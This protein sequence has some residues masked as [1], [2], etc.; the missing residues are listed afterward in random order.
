VR[1]SS[2]RFR[3]FNYHVYDDSPKQL[4]LFPL[5]FAEYV[6]TVGLQQFEG[7]RQVVILEHRLVVV[8][9]RQLGTC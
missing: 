6:A 8:N 9:E 1:A 4:T 3:P 5:Q 2:E 7:D